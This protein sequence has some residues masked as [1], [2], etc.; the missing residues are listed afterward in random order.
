MHGHPRA[1]R[2][3]RHPCAYVQFSSTVLEAKVPQRT[4]RSL[5]GDRLWRAESDHR[6]TSP[7]AGPG[8]PP[9][10][11]QL[12]PSRA[13]GRRGYS[14]NAPRPVTVRHGC[15]RVRASKESPP[16]QQE[17][18]RPDRVGP[19]SLSGSPL[20]ATDVISVGLRRVVGV[21][22]VRG[23]IGAGFHR[24]S[25]APGRSSTA[26]ARPEV[27]SLEGHVAEFVGEAFN[28]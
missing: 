7:R 4:S 11:R 22:N 8:R 5:H 1:P 9:Q 16:N 27:R 14:L 13:N 25:S 6:K 20:I 3:A 18:H 19:I 2:L 12:D 17:V 28:S 21:A 15:P 26:R 23:Q 24:G 10:R